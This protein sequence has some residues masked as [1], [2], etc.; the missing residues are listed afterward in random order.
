MTNSASVTRWLDYLSIFGHLQQK[1]FAQK[2]L[3]N[4]GKVGS[5]FGQILEKLSE[6]IPK[7]R[8]FAKSGHT[9]LRVCLSLDTHT[10]EIRFI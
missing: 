2:L 10:R 8:N 3:T 1:Q 5:K 9:E 7:W 4:F 6:T